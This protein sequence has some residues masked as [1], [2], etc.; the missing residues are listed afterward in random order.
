MRFWP[1]YAVALKHRVEEYVS[2]LL[3]ILANDMKSC[4]ERLYPRVSTLLEILGL[5][6]KLKRAVKTA[7]SSFQPFLR[8]WRRRYMIYRGA[9]KRYAFQPFLRF[10]RGI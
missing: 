2:T 8:F 7:A 9:A 6:R 1:P 3:E 10:W 4:I 5:K